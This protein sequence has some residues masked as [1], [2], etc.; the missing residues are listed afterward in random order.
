MFTAYLQI[1]PQDTFL[2]LY[3]LGHMACLFFGISDTLYQIVLSV[4]CLLFL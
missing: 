3:F 1:H 2:E 4:S